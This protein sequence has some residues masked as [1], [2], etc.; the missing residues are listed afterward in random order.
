MNSSILFVKFKKMWK[1]VLNPNDNIR[2]HYVK[3]RRVIINILLV[4]IYFNIFMDIRK[5]P[6][7]ICLTEE[8]D[9]VYLF[10]NPIRFLLK[11]AIM[12]SSFYKNNWNCPIFSIW[13]FIF[14]VYQ[15]WTHPLN[16]NLKINDQFSSIIGIY[17]FCRS[18]NYS[19]VI[20]APCKQCR[21]PDPA[22]C[23]CIKP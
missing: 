4:L 8:V 12:L 10:F 22:L 17:H 2:L 20:D 13:W 6:I 7:T 9:F 19:E 11:Y 15:I 21:L 18:H 16:T 1:N 5:I 3:K 23:E 14:W